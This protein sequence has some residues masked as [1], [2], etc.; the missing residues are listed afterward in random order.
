M[1]KKLHIPLP[2]AIDANA[3]FTPGPSRDNAWTVTDGR[4]SLVRRIQ[5]PRPVL[6]DATPQS[7]EIDVA[8]SAVVVIDMQN[9]FCHPEG[10]FA[11]KGISVK[12]ARKPIPVISKLLPA[13]RKAGGSV[14]W[15][16]WG[17]RADL[18]NLSATI[19]FKGKR[20]RDGVGYGEASPLDRG[21]ALVRGA[22]GAQVIDELSVEPTD[23]AVEKHRLSGFWDNELDSILR[24]RGITTLLFV[25]INTDRCVFST[26]Q[27]AAFIGYDCILLEDACNTSSPAYVTRAIHFIVQQLHGFV[28]R[29]DNLIDSLLIKR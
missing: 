19:H 29:A 20:S 17:I 7:L 15:L 3:P 1:K 8:R 18:A 27:D 11:Q 4:V 6:I 12:A 28:A 14:V 25:G 2:Q 10:W 23:I 9:D 21:P 13:W 5:K 26:L 24:N 22:W 16:N